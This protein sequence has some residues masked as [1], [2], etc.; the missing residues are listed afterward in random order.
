M[1]G[2]IEFFCV[3]RGGGRIE[4]EFCYQAVNFDGSTRLHTPTIPQSTSERVG[5]VGIDRGLRGGF[6]FMRGK[7]E[8]LG[9]LGGR[10]VVAFCNQAVNF[11]GSA[12][13]HTSAT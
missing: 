13:L 10:I 12:Q 6:I 5:A 1:R 11:Y 3:C 9:V 8:F 4:I 7:L 2:Q